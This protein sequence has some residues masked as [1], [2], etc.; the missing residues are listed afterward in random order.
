MDDMPVIT[1]NIKLMDEFRNYLQSIYKITEKGTPLTEVIGI[2]FT[3]YNN[4]KSVVSLSIPPGHI[5]KIVNN[6]LD[7]K[8]SMVPMS[9]SRILN[10]LPKEYQR[11]D[12]ITKYQQL[13]GDL[14][15]S[16]KTRLDISIAV[17]IL[18]TKI[19]EE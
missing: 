2:Q 14:F 13:L 4:D 5:Q 17:N 3:Y 16:V 19:H 1:S 10:N 12:I 9:P 18:A 15:Y 11:C 8:I 7:S 6:I